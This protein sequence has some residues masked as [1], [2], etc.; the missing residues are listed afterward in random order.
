VSLCL[1]QLR[2]RY[3]EFRIIILGDGYCFNII[4]IGVTVLEKLD[5]IQSLTIE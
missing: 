3:P 5:I 4:N 2:Q 1:P